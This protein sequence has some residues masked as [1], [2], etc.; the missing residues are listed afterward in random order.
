MQIIQKLATLVLLYSCTLFS[1]PLSAQT[2]NDITASPNGHL[3][4]IHGSNTIG[5]HLA[6]AWAMQYLEQRGVSEVKLIERAENE[7]RVEG[8]FEQTKVYIDIYAHGSSTGFK[9]MK[10]GQAE[11][12]MASRAIKDSENQLI[13]STVDLRDQENEHVVAIDGL[14]IIVN[15]KNPVNDLTI[16]Q[17]RDIFSGKIKNWSQ[18]GGANATIVVHARDDKSGTWDTFKS[19]VLDK[20]YP[21]SKDATRFESND[22]LASFVSRQR[23]AIG[24]VALA[25]V[26]A[27][28]ALNISDGKSLKLS[29]QHLTIA[30]EDYPLSRRLYMYTLPDIQNEVAKD[31]VKYAKSQSGQKIVENIGFISQNPLSIAGTVPEE[32]PQGYAN[33]V[34]KGHRLSINFR[35]ETGSAELDN[36]AKQDIQRLAEYMKLPENRDK[37]VQLIGFG[38][39]KQRETLAL[40][41]SKLRALAVKSALHREGVSVEPVKGFGS[42]LPVASNDGENKIRNQR[43]EVWLF[44]QGHTLYQDKNTQESTALTNL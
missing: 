39:Y 27:V 9:A 10:Q 36:K 31:F 7:T 40:A 41:F 44:D 15:E 30:T 21:L 18:V 26:S 37:R 13:S 43:V 3:F 24:F 23:N 12:A 28:K 4:S 8:L 42:Y 17:L 6:P 32:V 38:D 22:Q 14:A 35:F 34:E 29:P 25:S 2:L 11:V 16:E 20:H 1:A 5:A 33:L 19:L